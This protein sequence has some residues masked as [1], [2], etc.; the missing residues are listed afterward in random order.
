MTKIQ[1]NTSMGRIVVSDLDGELQQQG[2]NGLLNTPAADSSIGTGAKDI[3][4]AQLSAGILEE[5]A[6][7]QVTWTLPTAAALVAGFGSG[8]GDCID[9]SVI[10]SATKGTEEEITVAVGTGGT[11]VGNAVVPTFWDTDDADRSGCGLFRIRFT[12]VTASSEAYTLYR[13]A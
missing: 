7:A 10:N 3:T 4:V 2:L 9:L 1:G 12:N 5:D 8:V 13:I 11:L 6:T